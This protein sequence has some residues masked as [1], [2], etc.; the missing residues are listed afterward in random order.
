MKM[1][2]LIGRVSGQVKLKWRL[3]GIP[4]VVQWVKNPTLL[5]LWHRLQMWLGSCIAMA[6]V[7][8]RSSNSDPT[9]SPGT[10]ICLR[11]SPKKKKRKKKKK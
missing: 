2:K 7:Y 4:T 1:M 10:S 9:L 5:Q 11:C 8:V 3:L 6:V